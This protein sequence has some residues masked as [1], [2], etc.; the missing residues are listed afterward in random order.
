MCT[1][2]VQYGELLQRALHAFHSNS[3]WCRANEFVCA[4]AGRLT[5][6]V[7]Q[8]G[9][10]SPA[11]RRDHIGRGTYGITRKYTSDL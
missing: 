4:D 5:R 7:A 1:A 9:Q 3:G 10:L 6:T 2:I 8:Y 11:R